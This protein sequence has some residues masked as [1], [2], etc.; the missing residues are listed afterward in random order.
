MENQLFH[1]FLKIFQIGQFWDALL[2]SKFRTK[3][4]DCKILKGLKICI[5][6]ETQLSR[7]NACAGDTVIDIRFDVHMSQLCVTAVTL[8]SE[9]LIMK[10]IDIFYTFWL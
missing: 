4:R 6:I 2:K 3:F 10:H 7:D 8:H 5:I 9:L 1:D